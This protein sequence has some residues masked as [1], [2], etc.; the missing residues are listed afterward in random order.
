MTEPPSPPPD[1]EL[2]ER[3]QR[4]WHREHVAWMKDITIWQREQQLAEALLYQ[5]EHA[6]PDHRLRMLEHSDDIAAHEQRLREHEKLLSE[7]MPGR[8]PDGDGTDDLYATHRQQAE[9]HARERAQ[10]AAFR[11]QH[12]TAMA[13]FRRITKLIQQID[14]ET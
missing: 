14:Q 13:E 8:L 2:M 7:R 3:E 4:E 11:S 12:Q 9:Y 5:L 1:T 6:L 10:H